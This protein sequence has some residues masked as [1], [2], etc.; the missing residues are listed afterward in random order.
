[1]EV[2]RNYTIMKGFTR[3]QKSTEKFNER[4]DNRRNSVNTASASCTAWKQTFDK[5][6]EIY[7]WKVV[8]QGNDAN[9]GLIIG[10]TN[11]K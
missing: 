3:L 5:F 7:D 6:T 4:I 2:K 10:G 11:D 1:M 9:E 8:F